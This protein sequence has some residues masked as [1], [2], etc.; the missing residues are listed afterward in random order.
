MSNILKNDPKIING[1]CMYDWANSVFALTITTAIFPSYFINA[2]GGSGS[3]T[4]F[5][6]WQVENSALYSYAVS[7]MFLIVAMLNPFLSAMADYSGNKKKFMRF[8]TVLGSLA[9][10]ALFFSI[11]GRQNM[12]RCVLLF[13]GLVLPVVWFITTRTCLK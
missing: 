2:T 9:C 1:W 6:G 5:F 7:A 13:P 11:K 4:S 10:G 3:T 8:F 12:V